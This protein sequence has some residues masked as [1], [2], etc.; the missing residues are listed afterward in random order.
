MNQVK[1]AR[2]RRRV[3]VPA[4]RIPRVRTLIEE[5]SSFDLLQEFGEMALELAATIERDESYREL[6]P[7]ARRLLELA[8]VRSFAPGEAIRRRRRGRQRLESAA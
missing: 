8:R 7:L 1:P 4:P 2:S 3:P 5:R 6:S